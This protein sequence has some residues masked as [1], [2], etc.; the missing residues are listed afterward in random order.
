MQLAEFP[1]KRRFD[2]VSEPLLAGEEAS[3]MSGGT[4]EITGERGLS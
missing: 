1:R 4:H 2:Q 3:C